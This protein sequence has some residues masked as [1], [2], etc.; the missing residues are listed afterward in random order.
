MAHH[1][2]EDHEVLLSDRENAKRYPYEWQLPENLVYCDYLEHLLLHILICEKF[3]KKDVTGK[4]MRTFEDENTSTTDWLRIQGITVFIAPLLNDFYSGWTP[5][6]EWMRKCLSLIENDKHVY[7][8]LLKRF[9]TNCKYNFLYR[10]E[11][12]YSSFNEYYGYWS[13]QKNKKIFDEIKKL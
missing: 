12:L 8:V 11:Y 10:E 9:K 4:F 1:K 5:K 7:L 13:K 6:L 3:L 2:Y